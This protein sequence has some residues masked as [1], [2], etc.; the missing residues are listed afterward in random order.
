MNRETTKRGPITSK[1]KLREAWIKYWKE[2]PQE[3]IQEWIETRYYHVQ[4]G[5]ACNRDIYIR[6]TC[7]S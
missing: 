3:R 2:M 7:D 5:I 1:V 6:G 4:E